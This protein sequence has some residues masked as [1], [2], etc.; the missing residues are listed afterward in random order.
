MENALILKDE[1]FFAKLEFN[2]R[3]R[4]QSSDFWDANW[5]SVSV[6]I[7]TPGFTVN[8]PLSLRSEELERFSAELYEAAKNNLGIA[9][10]RTMEESL[11]LNIVRERR[12]KY[13]IEGHIQYPVG[14]GHRFIFS[15]TISSPDIDTLAQTVLSISK[16]NPV[17]S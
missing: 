17:K 10:L 13:H 2:G 3:D 9:R 4:P 12:G 16:I 1:N 5:I 7:R 11:E 15:S 6:E 8:V 14:D